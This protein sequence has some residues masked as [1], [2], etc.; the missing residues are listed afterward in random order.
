MSADISTI[1]RIASDPTAK[2]MTY[3]ITR[4]AARL[5]L[6]MRYRIDIKGR[7]RL[8]R[9]NA[10]VL[11]P[12][13][14]CWQDV[15]L[16]GLAT[17]ILLTYVAKYELFT[18]P[19][20]RYIVTS[21]GG[22]PLNRKRP[23][24]SRRT[25]HVIKHHLKNNRGLVLFPEGTYFPGAMGPGNHGILRFIIS[26]VKVPLI[27]VGIRYSK[28]GIRNR[29][30]IRFGEPIHTDDAVRPEALLTLVMEKIAALSGLR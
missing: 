29:V 8:P 3:W 15:P 6:S 11:L 23:I 1:R 27:P 7:E 18:N 16:V 12:K 24:E 9:D 22:I 25:L 4:I 14:Q 28:Q 10:F 5:M 17:P 30:W 19:L 26:S 20:G 2:N 13:H 21:L